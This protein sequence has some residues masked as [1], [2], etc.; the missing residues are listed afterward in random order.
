MFIL[1]SYNTSC[2]VH[3]HFLLKQVNDSETACVKES[4]YHVMIK[5]YITL[6]ISKILKIHQ[7]TL[8]YLKIFSNIK[9]YNRK[10]E[11]ILN[12]INAFFTF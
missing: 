11:Y 9:Y 7:T 2:S 6:F 10:I 5:D 3:I 1:T 8:L 12:I 4:I